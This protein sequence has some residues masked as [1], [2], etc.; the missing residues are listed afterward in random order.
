MG[1]PAAPESIRGWGQGIQPA[2]EPVEGPP[3]RTLATLA[4]ALLVAGGLTG[5]RSARLPALAAGAPER[6]VSSERPSTP[7]AM[8]VGRTA[9]EAKRALPLPRQGSTGRTRPAGAV[10]APRRAWFDLL[11]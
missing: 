7:R 2:N 4:C 6:A 8:T 11:P 1:G 3:L 9:R 5:C 10:P